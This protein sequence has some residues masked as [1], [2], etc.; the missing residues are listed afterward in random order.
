[1]L[2]STDSS[3]QYASAL[4]AKFPYVAGMTSSGFVGQNDGGLTSKARPT[5]AAAPAPTTP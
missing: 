2:V 4:A 5:A 3:G 1:M